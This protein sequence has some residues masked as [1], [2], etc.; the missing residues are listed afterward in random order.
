MLKLFVI[1]MDA[2]DRVTTLKYLRHSYSHFKRIE[3]TTI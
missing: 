2:V 1:P 3:K